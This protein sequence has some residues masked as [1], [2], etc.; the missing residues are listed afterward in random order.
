MKLL[1]KI[2]DSLVRPTVRQREAYGRFTHTLSAASIV[3]A[4]TIAWTGSG[5]T[6]QKLGKVG[7]LA[8]VGLVLFLAGSIALRIEGDK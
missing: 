6:F 5:W 3:G 2:R 4:F 7:G 1:I 8:W